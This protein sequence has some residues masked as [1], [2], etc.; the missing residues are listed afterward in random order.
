MP[1]FDGTGPRGMGPMSGRG[2]GFCAIS[3]EQFDKGFFG[4]FG[5]GLGRGFGMGRGLGLGRRF[6]NRGG[7]GRGF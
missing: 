4:R 1:G 6:R 5:R 3:R 7:W 2:R